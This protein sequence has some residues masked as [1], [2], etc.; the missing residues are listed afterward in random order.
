MIRPEE[1]SEKGISLE[2]L[3]GR[4]DRILL[5][6]DEAGVREFAAN[7]LSNNGFVVFE[8]GDAKKALDIK[9]RPGR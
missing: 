7:V 3:Q 4:G 5:V 9:S 1:N 6:E 8:A 2:E